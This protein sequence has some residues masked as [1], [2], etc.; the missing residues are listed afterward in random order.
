MM[1]GVVRMGVKLSNCN[2]DES[3]HDSPTFTIPQ[4]DAAIDSGWIELSEEEE[5][6]EKEGQKDMTNK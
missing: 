5:E 1:S 2:T 4:T 6:G 3:V